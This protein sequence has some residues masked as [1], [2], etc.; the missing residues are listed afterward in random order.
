MRRPL[1]KG[2]IR[3]RNEGS[4][5]GRILNRPLPISSSGDDLE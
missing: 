2:A 3:V 5:D 1:K 4:L